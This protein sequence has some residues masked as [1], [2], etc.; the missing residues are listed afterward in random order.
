MT[1]TGF[2][3][4]LLFPPGEEGG[5]EEGKDS[6]SAKAKRSHF[7]RAVSLKNFIMRKG[8]STSV[9]LGEGT[10][11]EGA[12]EGG[13]EGGADGEAAAATEETNDKDAEAGEK[14]E[15]EKTTEAEKTPAEAP[16]TNGENS[17]SN[18]TADEHATHNHQEEEKTTGGS[19]VKK[20]KEAGAKEEANAK[21]INATAAVNSG[22]LECAERDSDGPQNSS[23]K[24]GD[25]NN[26]QQQHQSPAQTD[27]SHK[28]TESSCQQPQLALVGSGVQE[29]EEEEEQGEGGV[30]EV[31]QN[32]GCG[33]GAESCGLGERE[34]K[35][36]EEEGEEEEMR[37][38][39]L[40]DA[41]V[42]IVQNV[43]SAATDQLE[44]ELYIDN[45][46]N[47]CYDNNV[48]F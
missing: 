13:E 29:E 38:R 41:A 27:I 47:G 37:K 33:D 44:R 36:D 7:G 45:G 10:K 1:Y 23:R 46:L 48:G 16:V 3:I 19:P 6:K 5:A 42:V 39:D 17:C 2:K 14:A 15:A 12:T 31:P 24:E 25:T 22:E 40:R 4:V 9:D 21:I 30:A 32:G 34:G 28:L 11:E 20:T 18:G 26:R 43:M 35:K 8:K